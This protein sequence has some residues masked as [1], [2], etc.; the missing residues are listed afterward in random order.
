MVL[1]TE[2]YKIYEFDSVRIYIQKSDALLNK[3]I[4][5]GFI[6]GNNF[7]KSKA[8]NNC[9]II[10]GNNPIK[11]E[12]NGFFG[13]H[14]Y[15]TYLREYK[16]IKFPK[17]TMK[18]MTLFKNFKFNYEYFGQPYLSSENF[19]IE[20]IN[21]NYKFNQDTIPIDMFLEN[22]ELISFGYSG[23]NL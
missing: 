4:E 13:Y 14:I 5:Q 12:N 3:F 22:A 20:L 23:V 2:A 21:K 7:F 11:K 6:Q 1:N 16:A 9:N 8:P 10:T 17:R 18:K 19:H 15:L